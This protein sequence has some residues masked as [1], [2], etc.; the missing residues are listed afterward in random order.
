MSCGPGRRTQRAQDQSQRVAPGAKRSPGPPRSSPA[1][2]ST[3]RLSV[4]PTPLA[5]AGDN[6]SRTMVIAADGEPAPWE[7]EIGRR[8]S[9]SGSH[10]MGTGPEKMGRDILDVEN[11]PGSV[12]R[13]ADTS[14]CLFAA[15]RCAFQGSSMNDMK[16]KSKN[17]EAVITLSPSLLTTM[18]HPELPPELIAHVIDIVEDATTLKDACL[19]ALVFRE[20]CQKRL[21]HR[22]EIQ[23]MATQG[24][25][26]CRRVAEFFGDPSHSHLIDFVVELWLAMGRSSSTSPAAG[27]EDAHMLRVALDTLKNVRVLQLCTSPWVASVHWTDVPSFFTGA[28]VD[29][30]VPND[31]ACY[32]LATF[33][34]VSLE[35][36]FLTSE[37]AGP[38]DE[39][40][41][42]P[43]L[44]TA[45][46]RL[47]LI[48]YDI[49]PPSWPSLRQTL[50]QYTHS[51]RVLV[52]Q[53]TILHEHLCY[54][55]DTLHE[56]CSNTPVL[57]YLALDF[58]FAPGWNQAAY[59]NLAQSASRAALL[60]LPFLKHF[61]LAFQYYRLSGSFISIE[62][63]PLLLPTFL[64]DPSDRFPA[65]TTLVLQMGVLVV[66]IQREPSI[67]YAPPTTLSFFDDI[68]PEYGTRACWV[69]LENRIDAGRRR[70]M[71]ERHSEAFVEALRTVLPRVASQPEGLRVLRL[72]DPELGEEIVEF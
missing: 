72:G 41:L 37:L 12:A 11:G 63:L 33:P 6:V 59:I 58:S 49:S 52:V 65:L 29:H 25:K 60:R 16:V 69:F 4:S 23:V 55:H 18:A 28:I 45:L 7:Y 54:V 32:L 20:P 3:T 2:E 17:R 35:N 30:G 70:S 53:G 8:H 57:E 9:R 10:E 39:P 56:L 13:T 62:A 21:F 68:L 48:F 27:S 67:I 26:T 43:P 15:Q 42:K 31:F 34:T 14:A 50:R 44:V 46:Q 61:T 5:T 47:S 38:A 64:R 22:L 40:L 51:L 24:S 36:V 1:V 66:P 19:A 71:D